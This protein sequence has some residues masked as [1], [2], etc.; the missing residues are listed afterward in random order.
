[1]RVWCPC[2]TA[3]EAVAHDQ[4]I[5]RQ[6]VARLVQAMG[7][8]PL[9]RSVLSRASSSILSWWW[10]VLLAVSPCNT[11]YAGVRH[12]SYPDQREVVFA[13]GIDLGLDDR[14]CPLDGELGSYG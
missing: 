12:V 5:R 4:G 11:R 8:T 10:V 7:R 13:L 14:S 3:R 1:M 2:V 6:D 9:G